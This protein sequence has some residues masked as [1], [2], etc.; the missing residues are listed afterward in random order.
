MTEP[1]FCVPHDDP[2]GRLVGRDEVLR[3]LHDR[4]T[5]G[6]AAALLTALQGTGG[7]GKT[8]LAVL[9]CWRYRPSWP[10]GILWLSMADPGA[11]PGEL[12]QW[13]ERQGI[14]GATDR[15][16][17]NRLLGVIG[18]R[19]D[20][21]LVLDNLEDPTLLDRD[22][23]G[24]ANSRP[25]GLGCR[26]LITSR[27]PD[28]P[29]CRPLQLNFLP[30]PVARALLLREAERGEPAGEEGHALNRLLEMLGGLPL[31]LVMTGRLMA[32]P[33]P[34]TFARL[35]DA[36]RGQGAVTVLD[37]HG[38]IPPDYHEKIGKSFG[39]L[40]IET[41]D[42]LPKDRP[43]LQDIL[44]V[45]GCLPENAFVPEAVLPLMVALPAGDPLD[46]DPDTAG[47]ALTRLADAQL[48]ERNQAQE[49]RLHPLI[50]RFLGERADAGFRI[51]L[52]DRLLA[53]L[54]DPRRYATAPL[55][56]VLRLAAD[57]DRTGLE[58]SRTEAAAQLADLVRL[59]TA[60]AYNLRRAADP[61]SG[62]S[63]AAQLRLA[64]AQHGIVEMQQRLDAEH[65]SDGPYMRVRWTTV[66]AAKAARHRLQGHEAGVWGCGISA[67][68]KI[69]LSASGDRTLIVWDLERGAA[70]HRL[71][72][73]EAE[74][75][76]CAVSPAGK[77]GL[78]AS[79]D[80]T[81]IVWDLDHGQPLLRL[82]L[83]AVAY[84]VAL[85]SPVRRALV[86]DVKGNVT[87][88]ELELP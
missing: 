74:V 31:A 22:I 62:F 30:T 85:G 36:L 15:E 12:T 51:A 9:Y 26:L 1:I 79:D 60:E 7:I 54:Q 34:R 45:L 52:G 64:A 35:A 14:D 24:L 58:G 37:R 81:L 55:A 43:L 17:A 28:L 86:G 83:D 16:K 32:P 65:G 47:Q 63:L 57:L 42:A 33:R 25:R 49:L 10:G 27:Q 71:Q 40:L 67:D 6:E 80:R 8:Q 70:R 38:Q 84:G 82:A 48:L 75:W 23:G 77:A 5:G 19:K 61:E 73:H 87:L 18:G 2:G 88:F 3:N 69:G 78:S 50:H 56:A 11:V 53:N 66:Q 4:L 21:L 13:A 41:W 59:L 68:G 46:L 39:A 29:G 76:G 20:A 44:K 72:V